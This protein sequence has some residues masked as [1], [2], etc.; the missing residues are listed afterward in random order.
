MSESTTHK[1]FFWGLILIS[2]VNPLVLSFQ[3][4]RLSR[5]S[6]KHR[7]N[8]MDLCAW[9]ARR[10]DGDYIS[11]K[12]S[13]QIWADIVRGN[14]V[15]SFCGQKHDTNWISRNAWESQVNALELETAKHD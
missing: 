11:S 13:T 3:I 15:C 12:R 1:S 8:A 6:E 9:H 2:I 14:T 10:L 4:I 5:E 7:I